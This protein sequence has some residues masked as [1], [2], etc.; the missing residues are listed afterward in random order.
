MYYRIVSRLTTPTG[1]R[2][3]LSVDPKTPKGAL[4]VL[5]EA[6]EG[7]NRDAQLWSPVVRFVGNER[8]VALVNKQSG[9]AAHAPDNN[10][11]VI[12]TH[13]GKLNDR[14]TWTFGSTGSTL[15]VRPYGD[16][17]MN[18]NVAGTG[19]KANSEV[20]VWNWGGGGANE[21]WNFE[22]DF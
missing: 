15:A 3:V 10:K 22:A 11:T 9:L 5:P 7:P 21:T 4:V 20:L 8:G 2:L 13:P 6:K 12:Q 17:T 19:P 14:A 16:H 1:Q 18:L